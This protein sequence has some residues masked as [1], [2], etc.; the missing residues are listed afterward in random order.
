[1][2]S[3]LV[4]CV[5]S[6]IKQAYSNG[7]FILFVEL[8]NLILYSETVHIKLYSRAEFENSMICSLLSRYPA[9]QLLCTNTP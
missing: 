5:M 1:M 8:E 7:T 3:S 4:A 6:E 2:I 9:L